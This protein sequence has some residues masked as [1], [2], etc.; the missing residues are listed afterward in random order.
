MG[1]RLTRALTWGVLA[2]G[3]IVAGLAAGSSLADAPLDRQMLTQLGGGVAAVAAA[4]ALVL[5]VK[6]SPR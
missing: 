1:R 3:G 4:A 2:G 6:R 5:P